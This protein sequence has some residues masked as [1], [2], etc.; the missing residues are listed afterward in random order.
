MK[1]VL[2]LAL[3]LGIASLATAAL[4]TSVSGTSVG[5]GDSVVIDLVSTGNANVASIQVQWVIT[6]GTGA[7][8]FDSSTATLN[9]P[10]FTLAAKWNKALAKDH[11]YA[12]SNLF[13]ATSSITDPYT[14]MSGLKLVGGSAGTVTLTGTVSADMTIGGVDIDSGTE[15]L[16]QVINVTPEPATMAL[17]GLGGLLLRRKK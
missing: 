13:G 2:V 9:D 3:V 7:A 4:T 14:F 6:D 5:V 12:G 8:T 11:E 15:L 1:K 10:G 16:S 17:L